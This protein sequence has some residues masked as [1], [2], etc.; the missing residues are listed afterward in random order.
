MS[1]SLMVKVALSSAAPAGADIRMAATI[2]PR[3]R[4]TLFVT[5]EE[6]FIAVIL[7]YYELIHK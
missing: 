6:F 4:K 7:R 3:I 5:N 2:S 1:V